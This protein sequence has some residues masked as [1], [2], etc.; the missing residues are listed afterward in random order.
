MPLKCALFASHQYPETQRRG[1]YKY[2][3]AL[4]Q[5]IQLPLCFPLLPFSSLF[6]KWSKQT[7]WSDIYYM[8]W[9]RRKH[10]LIIN[11]ADMDQEKTKQ[12]I[13]AWRFLLPDF[14]LHLLINHAERAQKKECTGHI[15]VIFPVAGTLLCFISFSRGIQ[16]FQQCERLNSYTGFIATGI[17]RAVHVIPYLRPLSNATGM[18]EQCQKALV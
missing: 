14:W 5:D 15:L 17:Q 12:Y 7:V 9:K 11:I 6:Q 10:Y 16:D 13:Y 18:Q 4:M 3:L 8:K 2:T 1:S